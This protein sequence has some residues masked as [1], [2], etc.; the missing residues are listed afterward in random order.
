[1]RAFRRVKLFLNPGGL[2]IF[3][4][5]SAEK[6]AGLDG[7][8]FLDEREDVYCVWRAEFSKRSRV[9]SYFMDIFRLDEKTGRWDRGEEL[10]R[11]RAYTVDELTGL[12]RE[13]GFTRIKVYGDKK[14]CPPR[15]GGERLFFAAT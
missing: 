2:F 6:L 9:C 10:H 12:L 5:N 4:I 8:V 1:M 3:D 14:M 13:A 11:E 15:P 7:Q